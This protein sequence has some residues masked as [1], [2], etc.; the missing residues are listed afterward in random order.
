MALFDDEA[1]TAVRTLW[2]RLDDAGLP[3]ARRFPPHVTFAMATDIPA[4]TRTALRADL[5]LLF[6][7]SLWLHS[8][9]TFA[10]TEH[11]LMLGAVTDGELLAVHSAV[12]DVLAGK[13]RN[14]N[15]YY[16]PGS[17][18][19]HCTLVEGVTE[20]EMVTAFGVA[21]PAPPIEAKVHRMVIADTTTGE[22]ETLVT[23]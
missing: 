18:I 2:S 12:H 6:I 4:K 8:L 17:W 23:R 20:A 5:R 7:P 19:P 15:S 16:L 9:S 10:T 1:D 3:A 14:P 22:L 11:T 13:V 21:F